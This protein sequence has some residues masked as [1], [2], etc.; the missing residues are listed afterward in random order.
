M[1]NFQTLIGLLASCAAASL[2][3]PQVISSYKTKQ[4]DGLAWPGIFLGLAN[5]ALW[6]TYGLM[7]ND[8]FIYATN[9]V[10]FV[11]AFCLLLLKKKYSR[12]VQVV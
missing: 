7:K 4:T 10:A 6:V 1:Q 3:F 5:A 8:P 9:S 11:G 2:F 12:S